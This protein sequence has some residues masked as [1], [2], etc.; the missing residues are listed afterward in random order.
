MN[1]PSKEEETKS[2]SYTSNGSYTVQPTEGKTLS[3]VSVSV[4]VP[5]SGALDVSSPYVCFNLLG[6]TRNDAFQG[7]VTLDDINGISG[8]E[9]LTDGFYKFNSTYITSPLTWPENLFQ[10]LI[11]GN[12]MFSGARARTTDQRGG[13]LNMSNQSF[14]NLETAREMFNLAST[15]TELQM[16]SE[17]VAM[18]PKL[19]Q[20]TSMFAGAR[21]LSG[22]YVNVTGPLESIGF[23]FSSSFPDSNH[24]PTV[25]LT[26]LSNLTDAD[27]PLG[28]SNSFIEE[29]ILTGLPVDC[30]LS[31][32]THLSEHSVSSII[33]T[34]ADVTS[35]PK[36]L[37]LS[38]QV[39][40]YVTEEQKTAAKVGQLILV[41]MKTINKQTYKEIVAE[42]GMYITSYKDTDDIKDYS[43]FKSSICPLSKDISIYREIPES[44]HLDLLKN[45]KNILNL[46][47]ND[48]LNI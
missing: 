8:W 38:T 17:D 27:R 26:N 5:S 25:S 3:E 46:C 44:E 12:S 42:D 45:K 43:G 9:N 13:V 6:Q 10:N 24:T 1:V 23:M 48:L 21:I 28:V 2:V 15:A 32:G 18:F 41:N 36:T 40:S 31:V 39:Q 22:G 47:S 7:G 14:P 35:N 4:N 16:P 11:S 37:T 29:F 19:K 34:L 30:N 33:T 20:A